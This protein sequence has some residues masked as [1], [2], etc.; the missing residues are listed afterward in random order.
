MPDDRDPTT[1]LLDLLR[2]HAPELLPICRYLVLGPYLAQGLLADVSRPPAVRE[3]I[4]L[5]R[6]VEARDPSLGGVLRRLLEASGKSPAVRVELQLD[7][8]LEL[9]PSLWTHP[10]YVLEKPI[11]DPAELL[12]ACRLRMAGAGEEK[13]GRLQGVEEKLAR[14]VRLED[15]ARERRGKKKGKKGRKSAAR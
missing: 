5:K 14:A 15:K 2:R 9:D 6:V 4:A 10:S 8:L 1:A 11:S 3:L 12:E 7:R 13:L